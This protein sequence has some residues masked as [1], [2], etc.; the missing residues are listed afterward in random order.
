MLLAQW[1]ITICKALKQSCTTTDAFEILMR[2]EVPQKLSQVE[3]DA[4]KVV[5]F[6]SIGETRIPCSPVAAEF[7]I[8]ILFILLDIKNNAF[9]V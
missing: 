2:V 4:A 3:F 8:K 7:E 6:Q 5:Y 9:G 1:L